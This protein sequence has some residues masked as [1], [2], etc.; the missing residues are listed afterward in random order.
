MSLGHDVV[1]RVF[2]V[3]EWI[4]LS[5]TY[6]VSHYGLVPAIHYGLPVMSATYKFT[7]ATNEFE[8]SVRE[9]NVAVRG[10]VYQYKTVDEPPF[11]DITVT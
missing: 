10:L 3:G 11:I 7:V 1:D 8:A 9:A 5:P 6:H 2:N 4:S